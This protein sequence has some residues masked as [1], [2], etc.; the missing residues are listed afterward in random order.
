[1]VHKDHIR[2]QIRSVQFSSLHESI[3]NKFTVTL[4]IETYSDNPEDWIIDS[5]SENL[6]D[7][8]QLMSINVQLQS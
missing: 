7:D 5:I 4:E 8:E 1:M 3:M 2:T 6:E